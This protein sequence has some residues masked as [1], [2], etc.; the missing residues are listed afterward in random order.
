[1]LFVEANNLAKAISVLK[2]TPAKAG[3]YSSPKKTFVTVNL[4][5]CEPQKKLI[6]QAEP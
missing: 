1:M 5:Y 6:S 4:C 3:A 2:K